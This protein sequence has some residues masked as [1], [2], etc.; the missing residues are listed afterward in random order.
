MIVNK[1][2]LSKLLKVDLSTID[3]WIKN[4]NIPIHEMHQSI[5]FDWDEVLNWLKS[6]PSAPI[7]WFDES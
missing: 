4:R 7:W 3:L 1:M 2:Q 6:D 5:L